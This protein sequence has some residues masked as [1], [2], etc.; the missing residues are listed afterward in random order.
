[1]GRRRR[2]KRRRRPG[3]AGLTAPPCPG[4]FLQGLALIASH[5]SETGA[6][7]V[8]VGGWCHQRACFED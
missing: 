2:R 3:S 1:M 8:C 5:K 4:S 7:G 6:E